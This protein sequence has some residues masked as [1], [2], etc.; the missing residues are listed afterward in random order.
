M[1]KQISTPNCQLS[2]YEI[3]YRTNKFIEIYV[4]IKGKI[5]FSNNQK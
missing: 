4:K 5:L 2:F 1:S 3:I